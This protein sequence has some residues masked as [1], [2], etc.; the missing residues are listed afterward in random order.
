MSEL[1]HPISAPPASE[2]RPPTSD[3]LAFPLS[4]G[5]LSPLPHA[6]HTFDRYLLREWFQLIVLVL[7]ALLGIILINEVYNQLPDLLEA[8]ASLGDIAI[9]FGVSIPS[10]LALL[11]PLTL[12]VSLLYVLGQMHRKHEFTALR[13]AGVSL[14]RIT[15]P[16]WVVGVLCCAGSWYLNSSIVPASVEHSRNLKDQLRF[17]KES[18]RASADRIG[19]TTSVSFD[20]RPV[21]RI[22]FMNRY[23]TFTNRAYGLTLSFLDRDR[24]EYRRIFAAQAYRPAGNEGWILLDGRDLR[25]DPASSENTANT[26]F[27]TLQLRELNEDPKLMLL[28]DRRPTDLSFLELERLCAHLEQTGNPKL[29]AYAVRYNSLIA[30]TLAPLIIIGLA[31][32]FAV[33]GVRV[34]P[35]VGISKSIGLFALYYLFA[36]LG[37]SLAT[38]EVLSPVM[39]AWIPNIGMC[40]VGLWFLARLR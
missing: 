16:I 3:I 31:I 25:F 37:G 2:V 35:A 14:G 19:A 28:I 21:G 22:W 9:F 15:A 39:A 5:P 23:S 36:Q 27:A 11:L 13:A 1:R 10:Y 29:T 20:N 8:D 17:R 34:N 33:T 18:T 4:P 12:L 30:D 7:A 40:G 24:R 38:K 26:P 32:H 6:V